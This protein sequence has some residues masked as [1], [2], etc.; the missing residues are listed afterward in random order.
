MKVVIIGGGSAGTTC[1]FELRKLNKDVEIT[2]IEKSSNME[3]SPCALP[4]V[5]SKEI[6]SFEDIFIFNKK[7]IFYFYNL[8]CYCLLKDRIHNR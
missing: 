3:Y 8:L 4:Y 7:V 2:L 6:D 1:A 5:L